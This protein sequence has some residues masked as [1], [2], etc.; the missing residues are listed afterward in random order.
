[1]YK[2]SSKKQTFHISEGRYNHEK[3]RMNIQRK[4]VEGNELKIDGMEAFTF[5]VHKHDL[6]YYVVSE[7]ESGMRLVDG[8]GGKA[9]K[10]KKL[11]RTE[12]IEKAIKLLTSVGVEAVERKVFEHFQRYGDDAYVK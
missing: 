12:T 11:T 10:T 3:Q 8:D 7:A 2:L 6:G 9:Y 5:F 1:M 4:P